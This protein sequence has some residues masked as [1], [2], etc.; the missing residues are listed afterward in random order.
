MAEVCEICL[1][2]MEPGHDCMGYELGMELKNGL[3]LILEDAKGDPT[4]EKKTI[5]TLSLMMNFLIDIR[6][7]INFLLERAEK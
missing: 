6:R 4:F 3:D 7:D 1:D 2:T 5:A